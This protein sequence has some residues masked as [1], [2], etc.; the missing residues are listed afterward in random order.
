MSFS[1]SIFIWKHLGNDRPKKTLNKPNKTQKTRW[2]K[3]FTPKS[4]FEHCLE[5]SPINQVT[6]SERGVRDYRPTRY[7]TGPGH[8]SD[9]CFQAIKSADN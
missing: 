9:E 3:L 2:D 7:I 8:F 6:A 1:C 5:P 4:F